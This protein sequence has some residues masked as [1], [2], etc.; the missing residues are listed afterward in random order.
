[1]GET[2]HI[3]YLILANHIEAINGML[4]ISG[5]GWTEIYRQM[6][7]NGASPVSH[8]GIGVSVAVPWNETNTT[9]K[10][11]VQIEDDDAASILRAEASLN[12]GRPPQLLPGTEQ[13]IVFALPADIIFPHS[14]GYRVLLRLDDDRDM[15]IWNFTVHDIQQSVPQ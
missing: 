9:H 7:P 11:S 1:M 4:Y 3:D 6:L 2:V 10:I 13:H 8:I 12:V 5:G 15:K 14:G